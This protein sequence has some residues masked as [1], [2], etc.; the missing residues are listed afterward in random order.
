MNEKIIE[1]LRE[2]AMV[3]RMEVRDKQLMLEASKKLED[4]EKSYINLIKTFANE[5]KNTPNNAIYKYQ[6]DNA[7]DKFIDNIIKSSD[8][9]VMTN[10]YAI[11]IRRKQLNDFK[12]AVLNDLECL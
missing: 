7:L 11:K 6:I 9:V 3:G 12:R 4:F 2:R 10:D 8:H 1:L 5:L